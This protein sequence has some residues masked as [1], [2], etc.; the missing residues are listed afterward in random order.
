MTETE[1]L[2]R[3]CDLRWSA[4]EIGF[5][6]AP[7]PGTA[8]RLGTFDRDRLPE[9]VAALS[10]EDSFAAAHVMLTFLSGV[11][12][13]AFPTWNGLSVAMA[14]DGTVYID[15]AQRFT[16]ARRWQRWLESVPSPKRLPADGD[17]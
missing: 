17:P 16:L 1:R 14:A 9:L 7:P 15:P 4:T 8:E 2:L 13:E 5:L 11:D 10:R 6:P 12:Y 3:N